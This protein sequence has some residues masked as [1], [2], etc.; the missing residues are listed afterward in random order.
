MGIHKGFETYDNYFSRG[1]GLNSK[2]AVLERLRVDSHV[3]GS[4]VLAHVGRGRSPHFDFEVQPA[5]KGA[6][7]IDPKPFLDGWKLLESSAIYRAKG[8]NVLY[9]DGNY[10]IGEIMLLPKPLLEK[11]VLSDPRIKIY[12]GGRN[13]IKTGQID[14]R[15]LVVLAYLA[16]SDLEPTVSCLKS[17]HSE[18]TSSGNISEHTS[19]NAVDIAAINGVPINGHQGPGG[20]AE[21]TVKRLMMLQGTIEPH[22][23]ISLLDF[24]RNTLALPDH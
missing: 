16:E 18:M 6:P 12:P 24:G 23:I 19:G 11:R 10:S 8:R 3:I 9:G 15:V 21:Q 4:T 22:Q 13:D 1:V 17:G 20:V 5:G 2:N 14:R 7:K